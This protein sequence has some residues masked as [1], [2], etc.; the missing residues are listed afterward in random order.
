MK[1][2]SRLIDDSQSEG[3][4]KPLLKD[5]EQNQASDVEDEV[6]SADLQAQIDALERE[7]GHVT[8]KTEERVELSRK[9]EAKAEEKTKAK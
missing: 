8:K 6:D 7:I 4:P 2:R 5:S 3:E 9:R 1:K